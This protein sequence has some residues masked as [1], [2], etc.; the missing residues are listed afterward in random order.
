MEPIFKKGI[1]KSEGSGRELCSVS[2]ESV[3]AVQ[4]EGTAGH[5][6]PCRFGPIHYAA[7]LDRAGCSPHGMEERGLALSSCSPPIRVCISNVPADPYVEDLFMSVCSG[8][9]GQLVHL[10]LAG[11]E[12]L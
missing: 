1:E 10:L 7:S 9:S 8:N 3:P 11:G 2:E 4:G 6:C 5:C 12:K